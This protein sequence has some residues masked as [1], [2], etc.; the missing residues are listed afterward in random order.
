MFTSQFL[1]SRVGQLSL[2]LDSPEHY[3]NTFLYNLFVYIACNICTLIKND[4]Y[5]HF[6]NLM[7][8]QFNEYGI[9]RQFKIDGDQTLKEC[10]DNLYGY[11]SESES[12]NEN[13]YPIEVPTFLNG[14]SMANVILE[15]KICK[16]SPGYGISPNPF[17]I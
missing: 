7:L 6:I 3:K 1:E 15:T 10:I 14:M 5:R 2:N 17:Y 8:A 12:E 11:P 9:D 16:D 13:V 4:V